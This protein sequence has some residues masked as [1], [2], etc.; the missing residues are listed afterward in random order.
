[1]KNT[2]KIEL[3]GIDVKRFNEK[4]GEWEPVLIDHNNKDWEPEPEKPPETIQPG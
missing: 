4:T 2:E 3:D 1:M